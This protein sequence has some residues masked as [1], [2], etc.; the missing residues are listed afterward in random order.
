MK[1]P[2]QATFGPLG[3]RWLAIPSQEVRGTVGTFGMECCRRGAKEFEKQVREHGRGTDG[4]TRIL[5]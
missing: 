5:F 3:N 4:C 2:L 1:G